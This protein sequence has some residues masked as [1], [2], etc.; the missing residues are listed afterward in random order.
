MLY[1][2]LPL[3]VAGEAH[4]GYH[5]FPFPHPAEL[6]CHQLGPRDAQ[7]VIQLGHSSVTYPL[8]GRCF[9]FLVALVTNSRSY[10]RASVNRRECGASLALSGT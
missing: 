10:L 3:Q 8:P 2:V 6:R 1:P 4:L 7:K 9:W 5:P